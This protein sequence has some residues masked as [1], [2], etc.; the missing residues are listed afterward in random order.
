MGAVHLE[1]R[2]GLACVKCI[3]VKLTIYLIFFIYISDQYFSSITKLIR[4]VVDNE[5]RT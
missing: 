4:G 5:R 3:L 1:I 2:L